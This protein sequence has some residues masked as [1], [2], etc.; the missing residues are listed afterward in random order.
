MTYIFAAA[1]ICFSGSQEPNN[2]WKRI[3]LRLRHAIQESRRMMAITPEM[4]SFDRGI[5]LFNNGQ[6][7]AAHEVL[8]D[9]WRGVSAGQP[10]RLQMQ[11]MVQLAVAFHHVSTGNMVGARSV[12]E[13]AARNLDGADASFPGLDID[14]LREELGQWQEYL[15]ESRHIAPALPKIMLRRAC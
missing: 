2:L 3:D 11:G 1:V 10:L 15:G 13:R 14:R 5:D 4:R 6:F 8:E 12:L 9:L 7:F